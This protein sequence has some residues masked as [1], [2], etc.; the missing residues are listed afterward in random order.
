MSMSPDEAVTSMLIEGLDD[1]V[2]LQ[3]LIWHGTEVAEHTSEPLETVVADLLVAVGSAGRM[4]VG[5][6]GDTA[7]ELWAEAEDYN[8]ARVLEE[9]R[10]YEWSPLGAGCWLANTAEGDRLAAEYLAAQTDGL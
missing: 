8:V 1:W 9:C 4:R 6:L 10:F 3:S 5:E 7:F 2:P